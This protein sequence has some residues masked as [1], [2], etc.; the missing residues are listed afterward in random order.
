VPEAETARILYLGQGEGDDARQ[1]YAIQPDGGGQVRLTDAPLGVGGFALW[2]DG[3]VVVYTAGNEAG[4][5]DVWRMGVDG[6]SRKRLLSCAEEDCTQ[7]VWSPDGRRLV[8]E[9][10]STDAPDA[11]RLWWLDAQTRETIPVFADED[12]LGWGAA[13]SPDGR[14]LSAISPVD[15]DIHVYE[16]ETGDS[17]II[18]SQTRETAV[19]SP[20]SQTLLAGHIQFQGEQFS[21]HLFAVDAASREMTNLSGTGLETSDSHPVFSPDGAWIAF[22]RRK[23]QAP[24]GKQ[25]WLMRADGSEAVSIT[26]D[27]DIHFSNP[28]WSPDGK[29]LVVQGVDLAKPGALPVL[30]LVDVASGERVEIVSP[31]AEPVWLP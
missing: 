24:M 4:G 15:D 3:E 16:I 5:V 20:G 10:R 21:N 30:W 31:G 26:A 6:R 9:R 2:P 17:F 18:P 13:L 7:P 28:A 8:Y 1:I 14:Y 22:S 19:W 11:P 12:H 23:P 27:A 25:L 29:Q